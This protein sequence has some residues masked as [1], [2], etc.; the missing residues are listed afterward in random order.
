MDDRFR[1]VRLVA[2]LALSITVGL[3]AV[4]G[5]LASGQDLMAALGSGLV[6]A[7]VEGP[8]PSVAGW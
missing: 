6:M 7:L 2:V 3:A 5:H 4:A 8:L 1:P